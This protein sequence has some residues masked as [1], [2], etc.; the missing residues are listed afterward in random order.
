MNP[1]TQHPCR[2]ALASVPS[3]NATASNWHLVDIGEQNVHMLDQLDIA[4]MCATKLVREGFTVLSVH[5]EHHRPVVWIQNGSL[6]GELEGAVMI[7]RPGP[8]GIENI[9][10]APLEGCQVQWIVRG[11]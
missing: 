9:M 3:A 10:A 6:C 11:H 1:K 5:V 7:R 4:Y 2:A 8:H